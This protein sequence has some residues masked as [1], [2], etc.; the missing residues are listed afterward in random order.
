VSKRRTKPTPPPTP[1]TPKTLPPPVVFKPGTEPHI[2]RIGNDLTESER[3][4]AALQRLRE[5]HDG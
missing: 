2:C 1:T 4:A 5:A 3:A